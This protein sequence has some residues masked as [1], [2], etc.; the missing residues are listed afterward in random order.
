MS[1]K[2]PSI[3]KVR[4]EQNVHS[5]TTGQTRDPR[6]RDTYGR[7]SEGAHQAVREWVY[8]VMRVVIGGAHLKLRAMTA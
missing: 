2:G 8:L 4:G 3:E 6:A 1:H 5:H 7:V